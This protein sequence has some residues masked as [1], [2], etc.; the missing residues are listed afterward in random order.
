MCHI[1]GTVICE[2]SHLNILKLYMTEKVV[3]LT[4]I[5]ANLYF[6]FSL[7]SQH[8][9][10]GYGRLTFYFRYFLITQ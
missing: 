8:T 7:S 5:T 3:S 9:T 1:S 6:T 4:E 2:W 10:P